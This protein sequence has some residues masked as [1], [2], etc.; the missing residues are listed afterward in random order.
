MIKLSSTDQ[1]HLE[2]TRIRD[3]GKSYITN[4]FPDPDKNNLWITL[5]IFYFDAIGESAFF[6]KKNESFYNVYFCSAS[7]DSLNEGVRQIKKM[8]PAEILVF[9]IIGTEQI[10]EQVNEVLKTNGYSLYTSLTRMSRLIKSEEEFAGNDAVRFANAA[11]LAEINRLLHVY[12]DEYAEQLPLIDEISAWTDSLRLLLYVENESIIG[13]TIF[14]I[15]GMTSYL[16]YWFVHPEHRNKS[17]GSTLL[18]KFFHEG[19]KT[20]RQLF[21]VIEDN[22]NAIV[23][24]EHYGFVKE[25]LRD[26]VFINIDKKYENKSN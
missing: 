14:D 15:I 11:D 22:V 9:D 10:V 18:R 2:I 3:Y 26:Y 4:L 23:R 19:R 16:R 8:Y 21:W 1:M 6:F 13:F 24:Y 17:I 7:M 5:G 12:F 20:K 25:T